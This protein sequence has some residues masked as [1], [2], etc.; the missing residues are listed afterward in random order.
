[1]TTL[2]YQ[3]IELRK[4]EFDPIAKATE[5]ATA[6]IKEH[7]TLIESGA[8]LRMSFHLKAVKER[9]SKFTN[10]EA[11][12]RLLSAPGAANIVDGG[13]RAS[14]GVP[15]AKDA[16]FVLDFANRKYMYQKRAIH[17]TALEQLALYKKLV[18]RMDDIPYW[19]R[20]LSG[21]RKKFG[22]DFLEGLV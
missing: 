3:D 15:K 14:V 8:M 22:Q 11:L 16:G 12:R 13:G 19:S 20:I 21:M 2:T 7:G 18:L 17:L 5:A 6:F 10:A 1:M 9:S 4:G